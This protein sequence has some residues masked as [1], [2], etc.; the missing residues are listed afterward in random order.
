MG[1]EM[2]AAV[3]IQFSGLWMPSGSC[4]Q[5]SATSAKTMINIWQKIFYKCW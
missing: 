5:G 3:E 1:D 2:M 4:G